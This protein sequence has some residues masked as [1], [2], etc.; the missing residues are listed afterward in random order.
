MKYVKNAK[1]FMLLSIVILIAGIVA[2]IWQGGLN[3]GIDFTG[4]SIIT[5]NMAAIATAKATVAAT[6]ATDLAKP[7]ATGIGKGPFT[8]PFLLWQGMRPAMRQAGRFIYRENICRIQRRPLH[9]PRLP[10]RGNA[11]EIRGLLPSGWNHARHLC[12][13]V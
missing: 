13:A 5:M 7:A 10:S 9:L 4:G 8:G 2:G 6:N 12:A 1:K 3:L 11:R